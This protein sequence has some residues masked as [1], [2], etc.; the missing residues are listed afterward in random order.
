M[1]LFS[2]AAL[3]NGRVQLLMDCGALLPA[4]RPL[5]IMGFAFLGNLLKSK[6]GHLSV[7]KFKVVVRVE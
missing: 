4:G 5:T 7:T 6:S 2:R 1:L 3:V